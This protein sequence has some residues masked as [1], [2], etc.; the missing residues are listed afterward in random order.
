[1]SGH[2]HTSFDAL[3]NSLFYV[4]VVI[5]WHR[6]PM[7]SEYPPSH[8]QR[9]GA[10]TVARAPVMQQPRGAMHLD[11]AKFCYR[12]CTRSYAECPAQI[13]QRLPG[14]RDRP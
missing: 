12:S 3:Y 8:L 11:A 10:P 14:Y 2:G 9:V 5:D 7:Y 6:V 4:E 13:E 1:M